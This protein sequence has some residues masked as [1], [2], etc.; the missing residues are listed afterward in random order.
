MVHKPIAIRET[1]RKSLRIPMNTT[2]VILAISIVTFQPGYLFFP[3]KG[4]CMVQLNPVMVRH[5]NSIER[6]TISIFG[7]TA[8]S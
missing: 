6:K 3:R 4:V 2:S 1:I 8:P 5:K 7:T